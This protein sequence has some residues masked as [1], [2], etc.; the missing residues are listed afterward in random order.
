MD[1][2]RIVEKRISHSEGV[3]SLQALA[4]FTDETTFDIANADILNRRLLL[5]RQC[6]WRLPL[7]A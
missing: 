1:F 3:L 5:D 2:Q 7:G 4:R 6:A